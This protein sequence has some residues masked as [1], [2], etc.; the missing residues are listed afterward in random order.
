MSLRI[1]I[2]ED[3]EYYANTLYDSI[4]D[5]AKQKMIAVETHIYRN[6]EQFY[7]AWDRGIFD[8]I[9]LDI[10]LGSS[11]EGTDIARQIR[12]AQDGA[13]IIFV[14]S[15]SDRI[16]EGYEYQAEQYL[17]KPIVKEKLF[18][19][20]ER[21]SNRI[22]KLDRE[23]FIIKKR[24]FIVRIPYDDI[25]YFSKQ[26][27]V[28]HVHTQSEV[29]N[30]LIGF[31]DLMQGIPPQYR[32]NFVQCFRSCIVNLAYIYSMNRSK[33]ILVNGAELT[34]S[35]NYL[36]SVRDAYGEFYSK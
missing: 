14:T 1:A 30:V 34:M 29:H 5:F 33:I 9:F 17:V 31:R 7:F 28:T 13:A 35:E 6:A 36:S 10:Y 21:I 16:S 25:L 8:A 32:G 19:C 23:A 22:K 20:L 4:S 24:D 15:A 26:L 18:A 3:E 11:D 12:Q 2:V 27:H